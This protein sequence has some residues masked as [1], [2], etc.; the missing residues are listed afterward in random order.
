M[1]PLRVSCVLLVNS[2]GLSSL[3]LL[4]RQ[5]YEMVLIASYVKQ[6]HQKMATETKMNAAASSGGLAGEKITSL[7]VEL[8][9]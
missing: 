5:G 8:V 2:W 1:I 6:S 7:L 3:P 9:S 4:I